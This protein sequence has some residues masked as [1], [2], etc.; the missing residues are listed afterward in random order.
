MEIIRDTK[1]ASEIAASSILNVE[2]Q[3]ILSEA[4]KS[5]PSDIWK[6]IVLAEQTDPP[7]PPPSYIYTSAG[8]MGM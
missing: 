3:D 7:A 6:A 5:I 4:A 8:T 1:K 2:A